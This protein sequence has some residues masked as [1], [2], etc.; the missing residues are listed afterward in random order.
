MTG[1]RSEKRVKWMLFELLATDAPFTCRLHY[2]PR[3]VSTLRALL[4]IV[5]VLYVEI[6]FAHDCLCLNWGVVIGER[7]I[8]VIL[9]ASWN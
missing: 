3:N 2:V 7:Q 5:V 4:Y 8:L 1:L 9:L 6:D